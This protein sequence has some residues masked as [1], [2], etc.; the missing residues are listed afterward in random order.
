MSF[1]IL[2]YFYASLFIDVAIFVF[3]YLVP[4]GKNEKFLLDFSK[5]VLMLLFSE[6]LRR[7]RKLC[8]KRIS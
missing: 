6:C 2:L 1:N 4:R 7:R 3:K 5:I 8:L